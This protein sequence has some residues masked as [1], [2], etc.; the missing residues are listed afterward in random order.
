MLLLKYFYLTLVFLLELIMF[1]SFSYWGFQKGQSLIT[2]CLLA[3]LLLAVSTTLWA[4]FAAPK[5]T[6]RLDFPL[7]LIFELSLFLLAAFALYKLN[8]STAAMLYA[9]L[10]ILSIAIAFIFKL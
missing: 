1:F 8:Y 7:R 6:T 4:I 3:I 9:I 10:A 2:K 5:A